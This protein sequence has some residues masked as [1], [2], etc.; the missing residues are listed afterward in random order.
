[1]TDRLLRLLLLLGTCKPRRGESE[2]VLKIQTALSHEHFIHETRERKYEASSTLTGYQTP[3]G[4]RAPLTVPAKWRS[5]D[6]V[7]FPSAGPAIDLLLATIARHN[8][9]TKIKQ[10]VT[11]A[12]EVAALSEKT[13]A[14]SKA[15]AN[16]DA[17]GAS[18][19]PLS[20]DEDD[21]KPL[22]INLYAKPSVGIV[23]GP[24]TLADIDAF[25]T[26]YR[27]TCTKNQN[28]DR[29]V[30][31]QKKVYKKLQRDW[32]AMVRSSTYWH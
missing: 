11:A 28:C 7:H 22:A 23:V 21:V 2:A 31:W 25:N 29:R 27:F 3:Y 19:I 12:A 18:T 30:P 8:E 14:A 32:D 6:V 13:N 15:A 24:K 9:E 20:S 17:D 5:E 16:A 1:M 4:V 10:Y 26:Q